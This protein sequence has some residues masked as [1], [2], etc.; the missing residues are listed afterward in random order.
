[1]KLKFK[2]NEYLLYLT[3]PSLNDLL[4]LSRMSFIYVE[5]AGDLIIVMTVG[6]E[7]PKC[8]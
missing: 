7:Q 6:C 8:S 1:M 5:E 3:N 2:K 4:T